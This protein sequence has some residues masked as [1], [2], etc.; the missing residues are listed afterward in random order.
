MSAGRRSWVRNCL[1]ILRQYVLTQ[2]DSSRLASRMCKFCLWRSAKLL[3]SRVRLSAI[4]KPSSNQSSSSLS[5]PVRCTCGVRSVSVESYSQTAFD[6]PVPGR[7]LYNTAAWQQLAAAATQPL[8]VAIPIIQVLAA[9]FP[10]RVDGW[11]GI[12]F[13][14]YYLLMTPLLFQA[15]P[16]IARHKLSGRAC[17]GVYITYTAVLVTGMCSAAVDASFDRLPLESFMCSYDLCLTLLLLLRMF[18]VGAA[19]SRSQPGLVL[20][21]VLRLRLHLV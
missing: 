5:S 6:Q 12:G 10:W 9:I 11:F 19:A 15:S 2:Q 7:I 21:R 17:C 8:W 4:G 3:A 13:L 18:A 20:F 14:V 16:Q 1:T